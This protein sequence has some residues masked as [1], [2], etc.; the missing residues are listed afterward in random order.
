MEESDRQRRQKD[1]TTTAHDREREKK[2]KLSIRRSKRTRKQGTWRTEELQ[3]LLSLLNSTG[4]LLAGLLFMSEIST[5]NL[6]QHM[7]PIFT[8]NFA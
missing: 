7:F 8:A 6:P 1:K 2:K 4:V 5:G 3:K